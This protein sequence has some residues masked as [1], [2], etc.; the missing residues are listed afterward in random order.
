VAGQAF[1]TPI[2]LEHGVRDAKIN[3]RADVGERDGVEVLCPDHVSVPAYFAPVG[4]GADLES[5]RRQRLQQRLLLGREHA[6]PG[7]LPLLERLSVVGIDL[8]PNPGPQLHQG[9]ELLL[10]QT[11][12]HPGGDVGDSVF[13]ARFVFLIPNSG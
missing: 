7:A 10:P 4:P 12:N 5:H 8:L 9:R 13:D 3:M 6:Q 11:R 1:I 2:D